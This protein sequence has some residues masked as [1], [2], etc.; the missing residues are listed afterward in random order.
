MHSSTPD[1]NDDRTTVSPTQAR[2]LLDSIPG[3]PRRRLRASDHLLAVATI[4]L[5]FAAGLLAV[6]GCAWWAILPG[7]AALVVSHHWVSA[8]Q[9]RVNEPRMRAA[10]WVNVAFTVWITIPIWRG[11]MHG[12][13]I[14]FPAAFLFASLAPALWLGFYAVLLGRR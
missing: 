9:S 5:S 4:V 7:V 14:P 13:T 10:F 6:S 12:E 3:R 11:I 1:G 8:R 2:A